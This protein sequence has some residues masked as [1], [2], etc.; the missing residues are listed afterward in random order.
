MQ[1]HRAGATS[2]LDFFFFLLCLVYPTE[3]A[4]VSG[5]DPSANVDLGFFDLI[6]SK[7]KFLI[8]SRGDRF[9]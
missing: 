4:S 3:H 8:K 2:F 1:H 9:G 7:V 5:L 6:G